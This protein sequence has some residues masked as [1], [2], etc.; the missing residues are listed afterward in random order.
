[1]KIN[2]EVYWAPY[3]VLEEHSIDES[4]LNKKVKVFLSKSEIVLS[5]EI[6]SEAKPS[7]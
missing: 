1:M 3:V 6:L 5:I 4:S 2:G 7:T